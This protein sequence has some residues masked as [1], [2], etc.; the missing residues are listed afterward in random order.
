MSLLLAN[1]QSPDTSVEVDRVQSEVPGR[2]GQ[3]A[4]SIPA[5]GRRGIAAP[6]VM[7]Q[8]DEPRIVPTGVPVSCA[9]RA[10]RLMGRVWR[11]RSGEGARRTARPGRMDGSPRDHGVIDG[12]RG[13][14]DNFVPFVAKSLRVPRSRCPPERGTRR[15]PH[16]ALCTHDV[17]LRRPYPNPRA[18]RDGRPTARGDSR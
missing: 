7:L 2:A 6:L 16:G 17:S 4:N 9:R 3:F 10:N 11:S 12:H 5:F 14:N 13:Y 15:A 8:R 18:P 1:S